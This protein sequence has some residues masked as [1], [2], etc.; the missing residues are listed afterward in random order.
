MTKYIAITGGTSSGI[1]KGVIVSSLSYLFKQKGY[2]VSPIK[3][4][5]VLNTSFGSMNK[6]HEPMKVIWEDE[7]I[8]ILND[9]T[10]ADS[11]LGVYERFINEPISRKNN[12]VNGLV[13]KEFLDNQEK[14][15]PGEVIKVRPHLINFYKNKIKETV[16]GKDIAIIEVGGTVDDEESRFFLYSLGSLKKENR[17]DFLSIHIPYIPIKNIRKENEENQVVI[18]S[19]Y[20]LKPCKNSI[21]ELTKYGLDPD[22]II[23]R[24]ATELSNNVLSRIA[25]ATNINLTDIFV[26]KDLD[27]IYKLPNE[28]LRQGVDKNICKKMILEDKTYL[29]GHIDNYL[30]SLQKLKGTKK[31]AICGK[32]ES[33]DSFISL[34]EAINHASAN[35]NVTP[36]IKWINQKDSLDKEINSS[37]AVIITEGLEDLE[38][39][40]SAINLSISSKKPL[41]GISAG[42]Q[43]ILTYYA[44]NNGIN[45]DFEEITNSSDAFIKKKDMI[46]GSQ[47]TLLQNDGII[48]YKKNEIFE[49]HRHTGVIKYENVNLIKD[50]NI[51]GYNCH[52]EVDI[53]ESKDGFVLG[54]QFHPEFTSRPGLPNLLIKHWLEL[55]L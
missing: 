6:Y 40:L 50:L 53:F 42:A 23:Y 13:L 39:K 8:Y 31:I 1:G 46:L 10:E 27:N 12:I 9:G 26:S 45:Y 21:L 17:S 48:I 43:I 24:A 7:E 30:E 52:G 2:S 34:N 14:Y 47:K 44:K 51:I 36:K 41:L 4:D 35:I 28:L 20:L 15:L 32:T 22:L 3:F 5:G 37:D 18:S 16:I 25:E 49:R 54:T 55:T 19:E 33:W 11:D 29:K 38:K